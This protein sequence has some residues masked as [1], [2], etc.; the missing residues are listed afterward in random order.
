MQR[1]CNH[2]SRRKIAHRM[3]Q[4]RM[5]RDCVER[6]HG[7]IPEK[8]ANETLL[9]EI[10]RRVCSPQRG[11][12]GENTPKCYE[13]SPPLHPK[14]CP[15][16]AFN[17]PSSKRNSPFKA[18]RQSANLRLAG[19]KVNAFG[20]NGGCM[21]SIHCFNG[22]NRTLGQWEVCLLRA[23]AFVWTPNGTE[24]SASSPRPR[25]SAEPRAG[26]CPS[27][28]AQVHPV[29][30]GFGVQPPVLVNGKLPKTY[31]TPIQLR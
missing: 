14:T 7:E 4:D 5:Q 28:Q 10:S 27:Q 19:K 29:K 25:Y 9:K 15:R 12:L 16:L 3:P 24:R 21:S 22:G 1:D 23:T 2:K 31:T 18:G 6:G 20:K 30:F 11:L 8:D 17:S 26:C 13:R